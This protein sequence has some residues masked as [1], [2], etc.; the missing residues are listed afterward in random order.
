MIARSFAR[1][2]PRSDQCTALKPY[3]P[4][5]STHVGLRFMSIMI[6]TTT[7]LE[8]RIRRTAKQRTQ[9][10]RKY[11]AVQDTGKGGEFP[12]ACDLPPRGRQQFRPS[13]AYRECTAGHP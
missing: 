10:P 13:R 5:Y 12:R 6:F 8:P 4:K 11:P 9:V 2:S 3:V 7:R 1:A